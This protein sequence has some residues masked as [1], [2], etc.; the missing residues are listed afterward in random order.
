[1]ILTKK[2]LEAFKIASTDATLGIN[3]VYFEPEHNK[4]VATDGHIMVEVTEPVEQNIVTETMESFI[5]EPLNIP[6]NFI[7]ETFKSLPKGKSNAHLQNANISF[8]DNLVRANVAS[9]SSEISSSSSLNNSRFP[10]YKQVKRDTSNDIKLAV[11]PVIL[12]KACD[13]LINKNERVDGRIILNLA[14]DQTAYKSIVLQSDYKNSTEKIEMMVMPMKSISVPNGMSYV[15]Y[16]EH[17]T[18]KEENENLKAKVLALE[19]RINN[20]NREG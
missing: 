9:G 18:L 4:T 16:E 11:S 17:K 19:E 5:P 6:R 13:F 15:D 20:V 12:K 8:V 10:D 7:E 3:S 1:M 2:Q 14:K